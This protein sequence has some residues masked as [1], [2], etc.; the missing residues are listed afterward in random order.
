MRKLLVVVVLVLLVGLI[1]CA[2]PA[3]AQSV[4]PALDEELKSHHNAEWPASFPAAS[5]VLAL[6][7]IYAN[8]VRISEIAAHA[9]RAARRAS[10]HRP[11]VARVKLP[12]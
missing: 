1:L 12:D 10:D 6:D 3:R 7:R 11:V 5:P 2:G 4:E 9:S 8:G